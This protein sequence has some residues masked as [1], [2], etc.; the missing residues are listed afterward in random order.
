[1]TMILVRKLK[2]FVIDTDFSQG[3]SNNE[4]KLKEDWL[5]T[6]TKFLTII[7]TTIDTYFSTTSECACFIS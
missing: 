4:F 6:K 5:R 3:W 7:F 1:M 2:Y